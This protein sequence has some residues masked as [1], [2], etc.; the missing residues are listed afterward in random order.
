MAEN[1]IS[2][3]AISTFYY[4]FQHLNHEA[5]D[6]LSSMGV[7]PVES[8]NKDVFAFEF[9]KSKRYLEEYVIRRTSF[10]ITPI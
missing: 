7:A 2:I 5:G 1:A 8:E 4:P 3:L 10:F 9:Q 6:L